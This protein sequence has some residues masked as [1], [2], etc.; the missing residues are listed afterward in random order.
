[1]QAEDYASLYDLEETFW[2][3][4]G[5]RGITAAL[6]DPIC[7]PG[8]DLCVLDA[9]CG[10]GLN[11]DWL[12]RYAGAGTVFGLDFAED[13]LAFCRARGVRNLVQASVTALPFADSSFDLVTSFDVLVQLPGEGS[14]A[15]AAREMYRVL[16]PG[17]I[18]FVRAA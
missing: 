17:G 6:L 9:G 12:E 8:R 10:T 3:F 5:M 2:W 15:Q 18:A 13:A 16:R 1:M 11:L 4:P 14:D 7:P